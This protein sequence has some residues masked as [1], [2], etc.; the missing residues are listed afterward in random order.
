MIT[1]TQGPPP[2]LQIHRTLP[3]P[4][5]PEGTYPELCQIE[6]RGVI[7]QDR[8]QRR[9]PWLS[10][11]TTAEGSN[12]RVYSLAVPGNVA[13]SQVDEHIIHVERWPEH[14]L[15]NPLSYPSTYSFPR[16]Q[17]S[18]TDCMPQEHENSEPQGEQPGPAGG[19]K[20]AQESHQAS[21]LPGTVAAS[22]P[23]P[24]AVSP[25]RASN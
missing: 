6:L 19:Q 21:L 10:E 16:I 25:N 9:R 17:P 13:G 11:Q 14:G 5:S 22:K 12:W 24:Y 7:A 15:R 2:W 20:D 8:H 23:S 18:T 4:A 3:R 1:G